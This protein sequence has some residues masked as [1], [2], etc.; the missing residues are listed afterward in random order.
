MTSFITKPVLKP[1][2]LQL[3]VGQE[4]E[5]KAR[6]FKA[7]TVRQAVSRLNRKCGMSFSCSEEGLI[8]GIKV[9]RVK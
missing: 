6:K 5:I 1:T 4:I 8:D 7:S 3:S 2:L 9:R